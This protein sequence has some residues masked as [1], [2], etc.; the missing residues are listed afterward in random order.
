M[1]LCAIPLVL[2]A[3]LI[4]AVWLA[5][6][7]A[8]AAY[9]RQSRFSETR[10]LA[11]RI[12]EKA[13]F[14][15]VAAGDASAASTALSIQAARS[16]FRLTHDELAGFFER[17]SAATDDVALDERI[18]ALA[19][20]AIRAR[21]L[22]ASFL[23]LGDEFGGDGTGLT[24][25]LQAKSLE[26]ELM[27]RNR[28]LPASVAGPA[29]AAVTRLKAIERDTMLG[30]PRPGA[31]TFAEVAAAL[32]AVLRFA[33]QKGEI[34]PE[35]RRELSAYEDVFKAW[36]QVKTELSANRARLGAAIDAI[37]KA[38][39]S[40]EAETGAAQAE[41]LAS[42]TAR[43]RHGTSVMEL[44]LVGA[45]LFLVAFAVA[46]GRSLILPIQDITRATNRLAA[47]ED[48]VEIPH[49][50]ARN[51]IGSLARALVTAQENAAG[52]ARLARINTAEASRREER[53]NEVARLVEEF[54]RAGVAVIGTVTG[55]SRLLH[56]AAE[57]V[58]AKARDVAGQ[59]G[60]AL[61]AVEVAADNIR[62]ATGAVE[63][64]AFSTA[65]ISGNAAGSQ[66][67]VGNAVAMSSR[68]ASAIE[69]VA[70]QART[71]GE[72][73]DLIRSVASQTNLLA[74]NAT[75]EAARAGEAGRGFAVVAAEVKS[76]AQ[77]TA[78]AT[79]RI[80][81][82][83]SSLQSA[84]FQAARDVVSFSAVMNE[85]ARATGAVTAAVEEQKAASSEIAIRMGEA[86]NQSRQGAH[87]MRDVTVAADAAEIIGGDV[88][89]LAEE[90]GAAA[91]RLSGEMQGF[92]R[93]VQAA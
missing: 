30:E 31:I 24:G 44:G 88:A 48:R 69:G 90:L 35:L 28:P 6:R 27:A 42:T 40:L 25:A 33:E 23:A 45:L 74:L 79:D 82:D 15:R 8:E 83:I 5:R 9:A 51:E 65:E 93:S 4:A 75:I 91:R 14:L 68:T 1:L 56:D 53:A 38:A 32:K 49:V 84:A 59:A 70:G 10:L 57:R 41:A 11:T 87:A 76:L 55:A 54:E 34:G 63:E 18:A 78:A 71:I 73:I 77:Q 7:D 12:L 50:D 58:G 26:L 67:V 64:L 66:D 72:V 61:E 81:A 47:G 86:M 80:A 52:R 46:F 89:R 29:V 22:H 85:V 16:R 3:A 62:I 60:A 13:V 19:T 92:L 43:I 37:I 17:L 2:I 39:S 21:D 36:V 20:A